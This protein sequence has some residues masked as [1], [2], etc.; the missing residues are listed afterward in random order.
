MT[1]IYY[2]IVY[3]YTCKNNYLYV[4]QL[5]DDHGDEIDV[6]RR[7]EP[8]DNQLIHIACDN[9]SFEIV[10]L[11][12]EN[13]ADVESEGWYTPYEGAM[14]EIAT[15]L[16]IAIHKEN[17][18]MVEA[19]IKAGLKKNRNFV[20]EQ[21]VFK[22]FNDYDIIKLLIENG[23]DINI[24]NETNMTPLMHI[25]YNR[26]IK[27]ENIITLLIEAGADINVRDDNNISALMYACYS[28]HPNIVKSLIDAGADRDWE[29]SIH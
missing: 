22:H 27:E 13:G 4:K 1:D 29:T 26:F 15:P 5:L 21:C 8:Y 12:I 23:A 25:C 17:G 24:R 3:K 16:S 14:D 11:L 20:K 28:N 18:P 7:D 19:I 9:N 2:N 10:Q 6:N